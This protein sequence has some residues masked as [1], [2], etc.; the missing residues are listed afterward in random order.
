MTLQDIRAALPG[1]W[2]DDVASA[3]HRRMSLNLGPDVAL[4]VRLR[5]IEH[6]EADNRRE[7]LYGRPPLRP[8]IGVELA[9]VYDGDAA[10]QDVPM[11]IRWAAGAI[12]RAILMGETVT[13]LPTWLHERVD[14]ELEQALTRVA[15]VRAAIKETSP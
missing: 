14:S 7:A 10:V 6:I 8:L 5:P 4:A 1:E 13:H 15:A 11:L 2:V 3:P 9:C 12:T